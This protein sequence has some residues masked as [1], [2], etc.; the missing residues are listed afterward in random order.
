MSKKITIGTKPTA[1]TPSASAEEWVS[2][3]NTQPVQ[4]VEPAEPTRQLAPVVYV[5]RNGSAE[6]YWYSL[7]SMPRNT[8][9]SKVVQMSEEQALSLGKRHTSKE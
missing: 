2:N 5:A 8:N 7:D 1:Q 4:P 6:V 3:R 9:F